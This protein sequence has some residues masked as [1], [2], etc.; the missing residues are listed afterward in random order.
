MKKLKLLLTVFSLFPLMVFSQTKL[1][2]FKSHSG[3]MSNFTKALLLPKMDLSA[4]NLGE[5]PQ[6]TIRNSQ[7]DSVIFL[8]DS[9][10]IMVTSTYCQNNPWYNHR[11]KN[12]DTTTKTLWNAGS[13]TVKNHPLFS[14]QHSL[15]SIKIEMTH[16]YYFRNNIENT[17][18][19]GY[20]NGHKKV[21]HNIDE[22]DD[23]NSIPTVGLPAK[24]GEGG[25][26]LMLAAI[27][28]VSLFIGFAAWLFTKKQP[29]IS[30]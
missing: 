3:N 1:I 29:A 10:A 19:I 6:P 15:D 30:T 27:V 18:F 14:Q 12:I 4:H 7:V 9:T 24:P 21:L 20:D 28:C 13:D 8:T 11:K 16:H 23:E 25:L 17:V 22:K 26:A 2:A 5:G